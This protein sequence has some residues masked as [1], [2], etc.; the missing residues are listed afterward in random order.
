YCGEPN[1]AG[2][3]YCKRCGRPLTY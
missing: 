2:A 1:P 3:K